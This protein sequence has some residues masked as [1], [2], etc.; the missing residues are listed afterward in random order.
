M[1][2]PVCTR[3]TLDNSIAESEKYCARHEPLTTFAESE[4]HLDIKGLLPL[5]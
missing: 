3:Y 5:L 4:A 2:Y 1:Q